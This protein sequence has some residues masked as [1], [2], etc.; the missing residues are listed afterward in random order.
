MWL[1]KAVRPM[2]DQPGVLEAAYKLGVV[3]D[4]YCREDDAVAG[5]RRSETDCGPCTAC[6]DVCPTRLPLQDI[7]VKTELPDCIGCMYC[8]WVCP[9]DVIQL[10]G[11]LHAME[12]QVARYKKEIEQL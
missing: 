2:T 10:D 1:K 7:G 6:E 11:S 4:V 3:Q 9:D 5:V 12:R 8:W